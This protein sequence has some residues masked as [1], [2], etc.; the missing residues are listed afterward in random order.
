DEVVMLAE[1]HH[2]V[3]AHT[4]AAVVMTG[5]LDVRCRRAA[6]CEDDESHAAKHG[7][8]LPLT[9]DPQSGAAG[10]AALIRIRRTRRRDHS[11]AR[12]AHNLLRPSTC[13]HCCPSH[14]Y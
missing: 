13:A 5:N 1:Q 3:T 11:R 6:A 14:F 10:F 12:E 8:N 2:A 7:C 4:I 9:R